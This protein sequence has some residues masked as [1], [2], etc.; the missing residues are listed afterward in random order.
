MAREHHAV[1]LPQD[2]GAGIV[3]LDA[4]L[5]EDHLAL[6]DDLL[7]GEGGAKGH[8]GEELD[9]GRGGLGG[10]DQIEGR[11]IERGHRVRPAA[12]AL[13][14][15]VHVARPELVGALEEHVLLE[16]GVAELVRGLVAGAHADEEVDRHD[17]GRAV[18][19]HDQAHAVAQHRAERRGQVR[20]VGGGGPAGAGG[21]ARTADEEGGGHQPEGRAPERQWSHGRDSTTPTPSGDCAIPCGPGPKARSSR[22]P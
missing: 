5:L 1:E 4:R 15:P 14:H 19:L 7:G 17:V 8:V 6:P 18:L 21:R 22:S 2:R 9:A 10:Q 11:V 3:L 12:H 20:G 13:H 16:V